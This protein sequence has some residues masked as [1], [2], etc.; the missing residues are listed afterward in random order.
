VLKETF[1][2]D[3]TVLTKATMASLKTFALAIKRSQQRSISITG[4]ASAV[5]NHQW[6]LVLCKWRAINSA[7]YLKHQLRLLGVTD[8][9]FHIVIGGERTTSKPWY[10][11]QLSIV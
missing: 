8:V 4:Y 1:R 3:S 6:N 11:N 9:T 5:G 7:T 2:F 10:L